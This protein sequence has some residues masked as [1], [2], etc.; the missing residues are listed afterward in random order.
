MSDKYLCGRM[1]CVIVA[2]SLSLCLIPASAGNRTKI[3]V[4]GNS[5]TYGAAASFSSGEGGG[6]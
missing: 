6:D 5:I 1:L 2:V 3:A 4:V